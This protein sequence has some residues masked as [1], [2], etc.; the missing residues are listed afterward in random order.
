VGTSR[1]MVLNDANKARAKQ[2]NEQVAAA[3]AAGKRPAGGKAEGGAS[4]KKRRVEGGRAAGGEVDTLP[5]TLPGF[6]LALPFV[7]KKVLVE[8]WELVTQR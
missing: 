3:K 1:L 5:T 7:L 4:A 2:I 6:E 8:D